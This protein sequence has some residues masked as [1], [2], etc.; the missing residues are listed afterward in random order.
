MTALAFGLFGL[1]VGSFLNVLILRHGARTI[2]G[3]SACMTCGKQLTWYDNIPVISWLVLRGRCRF[4][5]ARISIQYPLVE[6][7]TAALFAIVG[8]APISFVLQILALPI[9][10][11]LLAITVYDL[12]HT[13]IPDSWVY[14]A[15]A[16]ALLFSIVYLGSSDAGPL[17]SIFLSGPVVA[18]PLFALWLLSGG[19]WMG[20]GDAKLALSMG[21]LLGWQAGLGAVFLGFIIGGAVSAPLLLLSSSWWRTFRKAITPNP[22]SRPSRMAFTMKSEIPFGP[23]LIVG[24]FFVWFAELYGF[25]IIFPWQI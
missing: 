24:C 18:L 3:R 14:T 17:L 5:G 1:I 10:A 4:C 13:I 19:T 22:V 23:F 25:V 12:L 9:A 11:L 15:A 16:F 7:G 6:A 21:W 20:L 8:A 2:G